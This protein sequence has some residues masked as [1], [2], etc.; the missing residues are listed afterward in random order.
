MGERVGGKNSKSLVCVAMCATL[1]HTRV[2]NGEVRHESLR[3]QTATAV[4]GLAVLFVCSTGNS[5]MPHSCT[6]AQ[7]C[8]AFN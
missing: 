1:W 8:R 6:P 4:N 7:G 5:Q 3:P 2:L